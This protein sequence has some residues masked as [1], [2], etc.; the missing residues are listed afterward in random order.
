M[1][2]AGRPTLAA[3]LHLRP[4]W[5]T[6][7]LGAS[8]PSHSGTGKARF[9]QFAVLSPC[10]SPQQTLQ[11]HFRTRLISRSARAGLIGPS[12]RQYAS[13]PRTRANSSI[14]AGGGHPSGRSGSIC[15]TIFA[16]V[17]SPES[18]PEP[19]ACPR[20]GWPSPHRHFDHPFRNGIG[21]R[22]D[23]V[24]DNN[25]IADQRRLQRSPCRWRR[26]RRG[27]EQGRAGVADKVIRG[28][29]NGEVIVSQ[30]ILNCPN[31]SFGQCRSNGHDVLV[32]IA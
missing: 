31:P 6:S 22:R 25:G 9:H 27:R 19:P 15:W 16:A 11:S 2:G 24:D 3:L 18:V 12:A 13:K 21:Q 8:G 10:S 29:W 20:S 14:M 23:A 32:L 26:L 1:P 30:L 4:G 17:K 5:D 7:N 28:G